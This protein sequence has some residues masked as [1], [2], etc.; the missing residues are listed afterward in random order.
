MGTEPRITL[1]ALKVLTLLADQPLEQHY[2][3]AIATGTGLPTGTIYPI[4][5]RFE[6]AGWVT[7]D[8]ETIDP[9]MEGRPRRRFYRLTA[10]GEQKTREALTEARKSLSVPWPPARPREAPA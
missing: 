1:Q 9:T 7:S 8:W 5:T 10:L 6:Q 4:L 2:G 3:L